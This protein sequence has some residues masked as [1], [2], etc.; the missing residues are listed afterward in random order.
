MNLPSA[1]IFIGTFLILAIGMYAA[2]RNSKNSIY[3]LFFCLCLSLSVLCVTYTDLVFLKIGQSTL[4]WYRLCLFSICFS[5]PLG[6]S[7]VFILTKKESKDI[8]LWEQI[9]IYLPA[10]IF[11]YYCSS[12]YLRYDVMLR[13]NFALCY[14][15]NNELIW[16]YS[17]LL[18]TVFCTIFSICYITNWCKCFKSNMKKKTLSF[19]YYFILFYFS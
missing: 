2:I 14:L 18:Y 8:K 9:L 6:T 1:I 3:I 7:Y 11:Y 12:K 10:T 16:F 13:E 15:S 17:F 4:I 19:W 5:L